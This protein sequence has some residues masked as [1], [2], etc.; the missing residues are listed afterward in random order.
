MKV[1]PKFRR[2]GGETWAGGG[3]TPRWLRALLDEGHTIE[4]F[5]VGKGGR[6]AAASARK[7]AAKRGNKKRKAAANDRKK[8][9]EETP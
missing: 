1:A 9:E 6:R 2:L 7:S 5:A 3:A 4:E 8:E